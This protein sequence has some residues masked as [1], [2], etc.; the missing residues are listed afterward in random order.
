MVGSSAGDPGPVGRSSPA[1]PRRS[2]RLVN[3]SGEGKG[4]SRRE[5]RSVADVRKQAN[6]CIR[7]ASS[8]DSDSGSTVNVENETVG[9]EGERALLLRVLEELKHLKNESVKQQELICK[10]ERE[11]SE[12]KEELKRVTEQ[13]ENTTRNTISPPFLGNSQASYADVVRTPPDSLPSNIRTISSH[14]ATP[15]NESE[16]IFCTV[17]VSRVQ[18]G[19]SGRV[20]PDVIRTVVES[21]VRREKESPAWRCRAVTKDLKA[22]HRIKII[23]RDEEEHQVIKGIAE[24]KL[25][26]GVR[27][28]RDEYYPIKIDGVSRSAVLDERGKE[29]PGLCEALSS[30][31][32]T[33]VTN[34][35]WLS[36]RFHKDHGSVVVYLRKAVEAAKF[37]R[38]RYFYV[39]GLS[40]STS[41]FKRQHRPNQCYNC[42]EVTDHKAFQ[43]KKPQVC[44][45]CAK[46]GHHHIVCIEAIAKC[47]LCGGPHESFS[48]N[49]RRLYPSHHE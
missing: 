5:S 8:T 15:S 43:C 30:D 44:G 35:T 41:V 16:L 3:P 33:E 32:A 19:D 17:D 12:T 1:V 20:T 6:K 26:Q 29:L 48:K 25:P 49:C 7:R 11:V 28:L 36:H 42:Q 37:L 39:G 14:V 23:C 34:A 4:I 13:L 22:P 31:N 2:T 18:D 40:G 47:A 38:E 24:K 9:G 46:E 21:E 10:L 27:V 45:R